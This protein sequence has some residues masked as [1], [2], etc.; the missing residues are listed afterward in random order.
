MAGQLLGQSVT[1]H[2]TRQSQSRRQASAR[3]GSYRPACRAKIIH[4]GKSLGTQARPHSKRRWR[5][6]AESLQV[7][8]IHLSVADNLLISGIRSIPGVWCPW[9]MPRDQR[10]MVDS[11]K[12]KCDR[13]SHRSAPPPGGVFQQA[14][15][16]LQQLVT[17]AR[18]ETAANVLPRSRATPGAG[19]TWCG[20]SAER[21]GG[22]GRSRRRANGN[23]GQRIIPKACRD[24]SELWR[25]ARGFS[26][27]DLPAL[28]KLITR[29]H[30]HRLDRS[31]SHRTSHVP[32]NV[33]PGYETTEYIRYP[34]SYNNPMSLV[35]F[36]LLVCHHRG[37]FPRNADRYVRAEKKK[38]HS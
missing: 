12:S 21:N 32:V 9:L 22:N 5:H 7:V 27:M 23:V 20:T 28:A 35:V 31:A 11:V 2:H 10:P 33:T 38:S 24:R 16:G 34:E 8:R 37:F 6:Q 26:A 30:A 29:H 25:N 3:H 18:R 1:R 15:S 19:S 36:F 14:V 17:T 4:P 13:A